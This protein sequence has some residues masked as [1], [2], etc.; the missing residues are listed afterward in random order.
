[1]PAGKPVTSFNVASN[2]KYTNDQGETVK[3]TTW[4]RCTSWGKPA[5]IHNQYLHKGSKVL[6]EGKLRPDPK[7]GRPEIWTRQDGSAAADFNVTV[8]ELYFLDS[9]SNGQTE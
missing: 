8:K 6:I 2:D 4:F 3:V 1:T 7:T 5:E 9:R